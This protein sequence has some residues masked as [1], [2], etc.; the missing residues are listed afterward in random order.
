[1]EVTGR[2]RVRDRITSTSTPTVAL[3]LA[4]D[5]LEP[6]AGNEHKHLDLVRVSVRVRP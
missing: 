5:L 6:L 1:M 2:V 3:S 4:S